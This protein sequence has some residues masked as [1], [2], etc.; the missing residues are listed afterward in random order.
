MNS[1][2][3]LGQLFKDRDNPYIVN[4]TVGEVLSA[5]P[6]KI[7]WGDSI[8]IEEK[9]LIVANLLK[10]GFVVQYTDDTGSGIV[11]RNLT[12]KNPLGVGDKVIILPD[13]DF[14]TWYVIDKVG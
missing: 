4:V 5:A 6:L 9:N 10:N 3:K 11:S 8:I 12:I 7:K 14:R 1:I 2:E 13:L